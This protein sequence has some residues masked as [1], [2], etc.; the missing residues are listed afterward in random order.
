[1]TVA[2]AMPLPLNLESRRD[3]MFPELTAAQIERLGRY[4]TRM[5]TREDE[6][7]AEPG[8]LY[9]RLLVVLSGSI[10][11]VRPGL[12]GEE[13]VVVHTANHFAGEMS[14]LRG[15]ASVVRARV[16]EAGEILAIDRENLRTVVQVDAELSELFMRAFIL[17]RVGL[18]AGG[19]GDVV[20]IGSRHSGGTLRVQQF[21]TRNAYPYLSVDVEGDAN[22]QAFIERFQVSVDEIPVVICR[23]TVLKNPSNEQ[24]AKCLGMNPQVDAA[25]IHDVLVIGAGPAGLAAA[26]YAA[27]EGLDVRVIETNAPGGQA[28]SSSRIENYLGFPTGISGQALA[29]RA[30]VQAQ[31]FGAIVSIASSAARMRCEAP[32]HGIDLSGSELVRGR[33]VIIATGAAYRTLALE[34]V[35]QFA[36]TGVYYAATNVEARLC[37]DEEV[38]VVGGGNSAGQAAVFLSASCRQVHVLVRSMGLANSMSRYLIRR[39]E[40]T[41]NITLHTRTE[42][43]AL[44]GN[45]QLQQVTWRSESGSET[46]GIGHVFLMMGADPNTGWLGNCVV[47][48]AKGFV[49]TGPDLTADDLARSHWPLNRAPYLLETSVPGIFAVGDVRCGSIKRVASAVGEGSVCVSLVHRVL[50]E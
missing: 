32:I 8:E 34:N 19:Q 23:G 29:G 40:E 43:T 49:K 21:L 45:G 36:G 48:D 20:L 3:Q 37:K 26:V 17:R 7:L 31:K 16:R 39:I 33:A 30:L 5:R 12:Y 27:S 18:I 46:R 35:N 42:I 4:G 25:R 9:R 50:S 2:T 14:I 13:L 1:M 11:I 41:P 44:H 15:A 22:L 47:L 10:E 28:G 24:L 6:I 38:I